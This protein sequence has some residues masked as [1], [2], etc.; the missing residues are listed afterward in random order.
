MTV[1]ELIAY[2]SKF[3]DQDIPVVIEGADWDVYHKITRPVVDYMVPIE[4]G[5]YDKLREDGNKEPVVRFQNEF[6]N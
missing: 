2:L 6:E 1:R 5:S 4:D 3:P